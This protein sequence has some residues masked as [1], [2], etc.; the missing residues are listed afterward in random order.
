MILRRVGQF[1]VVALAILLWAS[2]GDIFRPVVL[3]V[4]TTPP[5]PG[6]FHEVFGVNSNVP[7]N[8]GTAMQIDV[9]GD[10]DI[11][12]ANMGVNPTHAAILPNDSRV[13][14][15][16]A[17]SLFQGDSDV[18][19]AFTPVPDSGIATGLGSPTTVSLPTVNTG[20]T[21]GITA[22]T[23]AGNL[24]TVTLSS[25]LPN[26]AVGALISIS[27][28]GVAGYDGI[29][30]I[31]FVSG[32]T[33]QYVDSV[34]GLGAS[35]GGNAT[36]PISCSYL[37]DFVATS[38]STAVFVANYG[39]ENPPSCNLP[40]TD[41]V[42]SVSVSSNA[43]TNIAYLAPGSHP[44]AMIETPD[45]LNLYVLNEGND[46][47]LDLSPVDLSTQ[48]TI[49]IPNTPI[50]AALREDG[51]RLY[52][53]TQGDGKLYT[54][55]TSTNTILSAQSV[56]GPG[57]NFALYDKSRNRLY[58]TNPTAGAVY[59]FNATADPPSL[60]GT[61]D[62]AAPPV[63]SVASNCASYTCTYSPVTPVSVAALPDGSR[64][65]VASYV[66]G[67]ATSAGSPSTCPDTTQTT[68]GCV[69]PQMSVFD[70]AT[71]TLKTT[72]FPLIP[73][74]GTT[75]PFAVA[76][77][78]FCAPVTPYTPASARFRMFAVAA[79]DSSRAYASMCDGG[80]VAIIN[81]VSSSITVGTDTTDTLVNDLNVPYGAG[82]PGTG[83]Q[84]PLQYPLF[85]LTG[86]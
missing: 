45:T 62:V 18:I 29:F 28:V 84:L 14:V 41:S 4:N 74:S 15:A 11:G 54:I 24:V 71:L 72:V 86:Q 58:V 59:I 82:S 13:F 67:T 9:S 65:Y 44:V 63:S 23:E 43:I 27:S 3:P 53:L 57:A 10:T 21:A 47:L 20:Q 61:V 1:A 64:F 32:T 56:G 80:W 78:T 35:S 22:I 83:G 48:A 76:P 51:Q 46:T 31:S 37:P 36:V 40:N 39:T 75:Q 77:V 2:C 30:S 38:Q 52:V 25:S 81:T 12:A 33:V 8:L 6:N 17:G 66:T 55:Q 26:A 7:F 16:S 70:A 85:L 19:T 73:A 34:T 69:I 60:M 68:P 49:P 42:A 50:W 5:T 79:T